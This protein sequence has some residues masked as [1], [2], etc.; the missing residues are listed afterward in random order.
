MQ[1]RNKVKFFS[2]P[3]KSIDID[4]DEKFADVQLEEGV[5]G[6]VGFGIHQH[7]QPSESDTSLICCQPGRTYR[8][9]REYPVLHRYVLPKL[10][11]ERTARVSIMCR[12]RLEL[13]RQNN[14]LNRRRGR[15]TQDVKRLRWA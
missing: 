8:R 9:C 15:A 5:E 10:K 3:I 1:A 13:F 4:A 6:Q 11:R 2:S 14:A 7:M 12:F